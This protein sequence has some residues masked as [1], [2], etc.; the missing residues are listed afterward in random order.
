V[1]D[2]TVAAASQH[3]QDRVPHWSDSILGSPVGCFEPDFALLPRGTGADVRID[4]ASAPTFVDIP[5]RKWVKLSPCQRETKREPRGRA[6][7]RSAARPEQPRRSRVSS[8]RRP[9]MRRSADHLSAPDC[10]IR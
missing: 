5:G 1:R 2:Q 4:A 3:S 9:R 6:V 8:V 10:R 7:L